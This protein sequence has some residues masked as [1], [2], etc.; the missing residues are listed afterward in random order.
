M[1]VLV[2]FIFI[3]MFIYLFGC[4][5]SQLHHTS[6]LFV[7]CR[8][9]VVAC[10]IHPTRDGTSAPALGAEGLSYWT[11]RQVLYWFSSM[12]LQQGDT[13]QQLQTTGLYHLPV[14]EVRSPRLASLSESED[15]SKAA[16]LLEA[17]GEN[18]FPRLFPGPEAACIP[19]HL[20][21]PIF[22]AARHLHC[23]SDPCFCWLIS[24][25]DSDLPASSYKRDPESSFHLKIL[26]CISSAK[27]L[28][29]CKV[30][31]YSQV[32]GSRRWTSLGAM[33]LSST[34]S[35]WLENTII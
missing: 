1:P 31:L 2:F 32:S 33:T 18:P 10:G 26:N 30:L 25:P 34:G 15:I 35:V 16:F 27:S 9:L 13:T 3:L 7:A 22:R 19:R 5:R 23:L 14:L 24:F 20:A 6:S 11:T 12:P 8:L 29:P 17:R 28:L 4:A 21:L